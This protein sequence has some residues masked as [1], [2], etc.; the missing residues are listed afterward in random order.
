LDIKILL[1]DDEPVNLELLEAVLGPAGYSLIKAVNGEEALKYLEK[2]EPDLI[3]LDVVMP[4]LSGYSVLEKIR[5]NKKTEVIPVILITALTGREEKIRGIDAGADDFISKPF[6]KAELISTVKTQVKLSVLRRQII[7]KQKLAGVMDMMIEGIVVTD[8]RFGI[9]QMNPGASKIFDLKE[10]PGRLDAMLLEKYRHVLD[11]DRK[12]GNFIIK[13]P[14]STSCSQKIIAAEYYRPEP[15]ENSDDTG[16]IVFVFKDVTEEYSEKEMKWNFVS[17]ISKKLLTPLTVISGF[18]KILGYFAPDEKLQSS[19]KGIMRSSEI[20]EKLINRIS[21]F[22]EIENGTAVSRPEMLDIKPLVEKLSSNYQRAFEL[23]TKNE[24]VLAQYWQKIAVEELLDNA[25]KFS[26]QNKLVLQISL[27]AEGLTVEDNGPGIPEQEREKVFEMFFQICRDLT[28][29]IAG[30]G[31]GLSIVKAFS[32]S[33]GLFVELGESQLGGLKVL[34]SRKKS[35][36]SAN[37]D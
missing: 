13:I 20:M 33:A 37:S 18:A 22:V 27:N 11:A 19:V 10:L 2:D 3:L 30:A 8:E 36:G 6:D 34:I 26:S 16:F 28:G 32:E 31:V 5:K 29:N 24:P 12:K 14:A 9:L 23:I 35:P 15:R 25:F 21:Y 4:G 17:M 7:E 1:V